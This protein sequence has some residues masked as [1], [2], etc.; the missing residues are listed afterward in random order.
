MIRARHAG[1]DGSTQPPLEQGIGKQTP[2]GTTGA[3]RES[4]LR[5]S[6]SVRRLRTAAPW[7]KREDGSED[8]VDGDSRLLYGSTRISSR[9]G[10]MPSAVGSGF[11]RRV[12][13]PRRW[14]FSMHSGIRLVYTV[15]CRF[16][17]TTFLILTL[18]LVSWD[19]PVVLPLAVAFVVIGYLTTIGLTVSN[20]ASVRK[21]IERS[22]AQRLTA[23]CGARSTRSSRASFVFRRRSR[24]ISGISC[25][26][27][28]RSGT[29]RALRLA[30]AR[31][32]ARLLRWSP[33]P[34]HS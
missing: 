15:D 26:S 16:W 7:P 32:C 4:P 9:S 5:T 22:R 24:G 13:E 2:R 33:Q 17:T 28:T 8:I 11:L 29:L 12:R 20:R 21:I 19:S 30:P 34:S 10:K 1:S 23:R 3:G 31:S 14:P 6:T 18:V 27:T 25:S